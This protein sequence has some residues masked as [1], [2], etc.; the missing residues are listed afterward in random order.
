MS[1]RIS[2]FD[3]IRL[4]ILSTLNKK[5][6]VKPNL[7]KIKKETGMHLATVKTSIDFLE[8]NN[9]IKGFGPKVNF[10]GLG[11]NVEATTLLQADLSKKNLLTEFT[12]LAK[13]DNYTYWLSGMLAFSNYNLVQRQIFKDMESYQKVL[14]T[15]YI[16][17][18]SD[19]FLF[20][21]ERQVFFT[22]APLYKSYS[23]TDAVIKL[24][25]NI[26]FDE[27]KK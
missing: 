23:R 27:K 22:V 13:K 26:E 21:K 10:Q 20:I 9:I 18:M 11:F 7:L 15:H 14:Q 19:Y 8:K 3:K 2:A 1:A 4:G 24:I 17:K 5:G 12:E 16:E 25:Q 6:A